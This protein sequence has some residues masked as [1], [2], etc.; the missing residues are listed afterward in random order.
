[1]ILGVDIGATRTK[2]VLWNGRVLRKA[3][4]GTPKS[5]DGFL[6]I[7][8]E[9]LR[10]NFSIEKVNKISFSI[11]GVLSLD[12]EKILVTPNIKFL[13]RLK[14][15]SYFERKFK[16]KIRMENDAVCF[17]IAEALRGSGKNNNSVLG[18]TLGTGVGGGFVI[19]RKKKFR[20]YRGFFGMSV[21]PGGMVL[22]ISSDKNG[23]WDKM[24]SESFFKKRGLDS[25]EVYNRALKGDK[26]SLK[27]FDDY[28]KILGIGLANLVNILDPEVI[29][30]GGGISKAFKFF[31][32]STKKS[33]KKFILSPESSKRVK[34]KKG[35][36]GDFSGAIGAALLFHYGKNKD[37]FI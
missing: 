19:R 25:K 3:I 31:Y 14:I 1:M 37:L 29:I 21:E 27:I 8:E 35:K 24:G 7:L 5:K 23:I 15:K 16:K 12:K 33:M 34:I 2:A 28:G 22:D 18:I 4:F 20:I 17:T 11:P 26:F 36:L 30:L 6:F 32:L 13:S 10:E 9:K